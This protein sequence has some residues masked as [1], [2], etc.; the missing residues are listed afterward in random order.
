MNIEMTIPQLVDAIAKTNPD[1]SYNKKKHKKADLVELF[2][3]A[4]AEAEGA[5][6]IK[7]HNANERTVWPRENSN[8]AK[9]MSLMLRDEGASTDDVVAVTGWKRSAAQ[10]FWSTDIYGAVNRDNKWTGCNFGYKRVGDRYH[11]IVHEGAPERP[12]YI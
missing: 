2:A 5:A 7:S 8:R 4:Q 9:I 10:S 11:L 1:F 3:K 12:S 6:F